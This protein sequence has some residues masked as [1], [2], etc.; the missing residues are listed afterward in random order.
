MNLNLSTT[1]ADVQRIDR[2]LTNGLSL[3]SKMCSI[4]ICGNFISLRY[5]A[6][7]GMNIIIYWERIYPTGVVMK[8]LREIYCLILSF[9][10]RAE[11][12]FIWQK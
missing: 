8:F 3:S 7:Q 5:V 6:I 4:T 10:R 11:V 2:L 1:H 12:K 9:F